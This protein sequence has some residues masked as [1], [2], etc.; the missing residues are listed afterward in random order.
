MNQTQ[1]VFG[2][3]ENYV[4]EGER[5][6]SGSYEGAKRKKKMKE[7]EGGEERKREGMF[8]VWSVCV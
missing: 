5:E 3:F 8:C 7:G 4:R 2:C 6:K 1:R